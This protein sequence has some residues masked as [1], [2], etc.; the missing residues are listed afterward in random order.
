MTTALS[1]VSENICF[2]GCNW[3]SIGWNR[4]RA[5]RMTQAACTSGDFGSPLTLSGGSKWGIPVKLC[6]SIPDTRHRPKRLT[7]SNGSI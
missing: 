1:R 6:H 4:L 7:N 3:L 2:G 5:G